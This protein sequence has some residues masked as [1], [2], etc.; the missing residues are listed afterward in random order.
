MAFKRTVLPPY[1][2][3]ALGYSLM[4]GFMLAR[5]TI[6]AP[7]YAWFVVSG[8]ALSVGIITAHLRANPYAPYGRGAV[9]SAFFA[10]CAGVLL[11]LFAFGYSG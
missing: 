7:W 3:L 5:G 11:A 9:F 10:A 8:P 2:G 4:A 1:V 6:T